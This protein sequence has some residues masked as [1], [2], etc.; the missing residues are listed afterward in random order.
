MSTQQ[1]PECKKIV[2]LED[3]FC[4][5][6][7]AKLSGQSAEAQP[8][9]DNPQQPQQPVQ[10]SD[11]SPAPP[12]TPAVGGLTWRKHIDA[13]NGFSLE[14]P[15]GW[16]VRATQDTITVCQDLQG[17]ISVM[18]RPI[19]FQ[20]YATADELALR[21]VEM[22]RASSTNF[23]AWQMAP[24][25]KTYIAMHRGPDQ[26]LLRVRFTEENQEIVGVLS[27]MVDGN[28]ALVSGFQAPIPV[29]EKMKP[30]FQHILASFSSI[31]RL[32]RTQF[33]EPGEQ[34]FT[35]LIPE[36]WKATGTVM[37]TPDAGIVFKFRATDAEGTLSAEVPGRYYF[38]QEEA[39]GWLGKVVVPQKYPTRPHVPATTF[40]EQI[41]MPELRQRYAD[42]RVERIVN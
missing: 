7:G 29:I 4:R 42:L 20:Q 38:F 31:P 9:E 39:K 18:I 14:R 37:R 15:S 34:A 22:M 27:V 10:K 5:A 12:A 6:C 35:A 41:M 2:S 21:M 3:S 8:V 11:I 32:P 24:Q 25:D 19:Q 28:T 16:E 17:L 40:L 26:V 23:I 13:W 36:Q 1:C 33:V 30:V